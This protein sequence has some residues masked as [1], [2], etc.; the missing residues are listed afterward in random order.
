[1]SKYSFNEHVFDNIDTE[2]KAYWLG[3]IWCDGCVSYRLRSNG[4]EEYAFKLDLEVSDR[5]HIE[6]F[7][8]FLNSTH[9]IKEYK[10]GNSS[11]KD[12]TYVARIYI[13][14][15]YFGSL[16]YNNYGLKPNRTDCSKLLKTIPHHLF[17]H[18][19]RGCIDADGSLYETFVNDSRHGVRHRIGIHLT[20]NIEIVDAIQ[21]FLYNE[22]LLS[23]INRVSK[24]HKERDGDCV[25]VTWSGEK[26][27]KRIAEYLYE[28][29]NIYLDRKYKI[30]ND[31]FKQF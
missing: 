29:A 4:T 31:I 3:F 6:K 19:I 9:P 28:N 21:L 22:G 8:K 15:K 13:C 17:K 25:S 11:F 5:Q 23:S 16:L 1:M 10:S 12:N 7:K 30:Y 2:E 14:N 18:F 27:N 24:R 26:Q 20:T